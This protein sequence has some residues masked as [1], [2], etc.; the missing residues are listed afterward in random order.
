MKMTMVNSGLKG[1][2]CL[3]DQITDIDKTKP[4]FKH[5]DLQLYSLKLKKYGYFSPTWKYVSR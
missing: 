4:V 5:T 3:A 2:I 1:L